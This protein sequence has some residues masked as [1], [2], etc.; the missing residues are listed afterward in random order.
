MPGLTRLN[1]PAARPTAHADA[2]KGWLP[3]GLALLLGDYELFRIYRCDPAGLPEPDLSS[4]SAQGY[5]FRE[6]SAA[7][8]ASAADDAIRS[9]LGYC[10]EN[11]MV[12]AVYLRGEAVCVQWFWFGE[13]YRQRNFWPLEAGQAKSVELFTV[14]EQRGKGLATALKLFSAKRMQE[15]GFR[16]L[17]SR[18]W[19]SH[20]ESRRV[21]ERAGWKQVAIV[22]EF[23]PFGLGR[24]IR[25]VHRTRQARRIAS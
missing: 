19:H 5:E 22:M 6:V 23:A 12:F 3:R 11:A 18:I 4:F 14:G 8:I 7:E 9:R 20:T 16:Q 1:A 21:S 24:T 13:R 25:L 17:F 10:G 15:K 2:R